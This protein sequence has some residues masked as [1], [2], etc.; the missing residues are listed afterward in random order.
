M[1][2]RSELID[3][4][5]L[6]RSEQKVSQ[7]SSLAIK[8]KDLATQQVY[9][10][11]IQSIK[12]AYERGGKLDAI[13]VYKDATKQSLMQCKRQ[14]EHMIETNKWEWIGP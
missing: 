11:D 3:I 2:S 1:F 5:L 6:I 7:N 9:C 14:V 12:E 4:Y 10:V 8:V 13:K